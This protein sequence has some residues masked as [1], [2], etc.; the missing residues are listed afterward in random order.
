MLEKIGKAVRNR[1]SSLL[2]TLGYIGKLL[3]AST[4]F[5]TRGGKA[6]RKILIMQL[7]FTFVEALPICCILGIGIGTSILLI[8]NTLLLSI[9]ST[10]EY[11]GDMF[12]VLCVSL[13]VS[14]ALA[15]VQIPVFSKYLLK[16]ELSEKELQNKDEDKKI[17]RVLKKAVIK[18]VDHKIASVSVAVVCLALA[19]WGMANVKNLFFPDFDYKQFIIEYSLPQ[20]AG[21]N[22]V[23]H[24]LLEITEYLKMSIM[25]I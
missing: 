10:G 19:G 20:E 4:L 6:A 25:V 11:A 1:V 9:G 17:N 14:W 3:T 16:K 13:L 7:L 8:G 5:I 22:R 12:L 21:P 23:K 24:D 2:Y 15:L 18:L